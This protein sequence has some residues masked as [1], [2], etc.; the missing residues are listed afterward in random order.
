M[1][2]RVLLVLFIWLPAV[3]ALF[4]AYMAVRF[5]IYWQV[6]CAGGRAANPSYHVAD[7]WDTERA[8]AYMITFAGLL[9]F[10]LLCYGILRL[11]AR[12]N[13]NR[14]PEQQ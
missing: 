3:L 12:R 9:L 8:F 13:A 11:L 4:P 2:R 6:N 1:I 7:C 5:L 10:P 14:G